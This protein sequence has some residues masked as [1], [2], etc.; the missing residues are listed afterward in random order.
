[1]STIGVSGVGMTLGSVAVVVVEFRGLKLF[2]YGSCR[3]SCLMELSTKI[4]AAC[5]CSLTYIC[6]KIRT[7]STAAISMLS[8]T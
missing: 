2:K 5:G 1:M 8:N 4:S 7:N 3:F 6:C